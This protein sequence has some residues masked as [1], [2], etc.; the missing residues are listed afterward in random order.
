LGEAA[1]KTLIKNYDAAF[2]G[3][4]AYNKQPGAIHMTETQYQTYTS[5]IMNE[6]TQFGAPMPTQKQIGGL[7]NGHVSALEY[8]QRVTD[9]YSA[10]SNADQT[11]KN[12]L[13]K[14]YGVNPNNLFHYYADPQN[15]L[16]VMQRQVAGA[17]IGDYAARVG[18]NGLNAAGTRQL[19]EMARLSATSGNNPLGAGV[20]TIEQSLL[21]A[22]KDVALTGSNPGAGAPTVDTK[23]LIGAAIPGFGGTTQVAAQTEVSRAEQAKAA[24]FNKGGGYSE[25]NA[26]VTGLGSAKT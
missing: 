18:L 17:E 15:A 6:A 20:S 19:A 2:S 1:D 8:N 21:G 16:P 7:L 3:L 23:T 5:S 26:G 12:A 10:V 13:A 9:I 11:T 14:Q 25:S 24:P 22:A 4:T